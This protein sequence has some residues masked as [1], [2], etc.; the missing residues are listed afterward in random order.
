MPTMPWTGPCFANGEMGIVGNKA[1]L[2]WKV[3]QG[4]YNDVR[5]DGLGIAAVVIGDS[6]FGIGNKVNTKT[7]LLVDR[8]A[9]D[10][11][12]SALIAMATSLAPETIQ[13]IVKVETVDF[14]M[15]AAVCDGKGCAYLHA[16]DAEIR[17]RCM[18]ARDTICGHEDLF[19]P[20]LSSVDAPYAA[21]T[22]TNQYTGSLFGETFRDSNAR[23]AIIGRFAL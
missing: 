3:K 7:L 6:T 22:L 1:I 21:Y 12:R 19:Y 8:R 17:T 4:I 9:T 23:S 15:Q 20:T 11:E 18:C 10:T 16:G 5:L 14:K 2:A 13:E